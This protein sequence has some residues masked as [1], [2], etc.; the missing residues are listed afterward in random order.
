MTSLSQS[1]GTRV[2]PLSQ[3]V[4][5]SCSSR[6]TRRTG[7]CSAWAN[8]I[9]LAPARPAYKALQRSYSEDAPAVV[10]DLQVLVTAMRDEAAKAT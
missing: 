8:Q 5:D 1:A 6:R 3:I 4:C 7:E 2:V 10:D 9:S